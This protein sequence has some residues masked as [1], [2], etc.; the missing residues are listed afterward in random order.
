MALPFHWLLGK[1]PRRVV[2]PFRG[3]YFTQCPGQQRSALF[4]QPFSQRFDF[5]HAFEHPGPAV[6]AS[7]QEGLLRRAQV[8]GA[9]KR[10]ADP[11]QAAAPG[12][13]VAADA[14]TISAGLPWRNTRA[15]EV[16]K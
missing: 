9:R 6:R 12:A 15:G 11:R 4:R 8:P 3:N 2:K 13:Q 5:F 7:V 1:S 16:K 10:P 14:V